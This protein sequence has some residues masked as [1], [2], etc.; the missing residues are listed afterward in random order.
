MVNQGVVTLAAPMTHIVILVYL[1]NH[2]CRKVFAKASISCTHVGE[3]FL[4]FEFSVM[5]YQHFRRTLNQDKSLETHLKSFLY[6]V[7]KEELKN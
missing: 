4:H 6:L 5:T 7:C 2:D 3:L 1:D